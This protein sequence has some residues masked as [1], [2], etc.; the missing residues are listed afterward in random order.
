MNLLRFNALADIVSAVR[1]YKCR[2]SDFESRAEELSQ[3]LVQKFSVNGKPALKSARLFFVPFDKVTDSSE[4]AVVTET[5]IRQVT[6]RPSKRANRKGTVM[7]LENSGN[8][9]GSV[10][11]PPSKQPK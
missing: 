2:A 6:D 3:L 10:S 5:E 4:R 7:Y 8:A 11:V 1:K 9:V